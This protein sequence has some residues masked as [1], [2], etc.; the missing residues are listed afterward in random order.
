M[1]LIGQIIDQI[2]GHL[3]KLEGRRTNVLVLVRG[4]RGELIALP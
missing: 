3:H 1:E 4:G 2:Q